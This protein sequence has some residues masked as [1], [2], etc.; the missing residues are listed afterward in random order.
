MAYQFSSDIVK[1]VL[2][3]IDS[4]QNGGVSDA[5][6]CTCCFSATSLDEANDMAMTCPACQDASLDSCSNPYVTPAP[7]PPPVVEHPQSINGSKYPERVQP[8]EDFLEEEHLTESLAELPLEKKQSL[9]F[10][11]HDLIL[12]C[13]YAGMDCNV[14]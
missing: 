7:T 5:C 11:S 14:G 12:D 1:S 9:G 3:C 6:C 10:T 8:R 2:F 4:T 13:K